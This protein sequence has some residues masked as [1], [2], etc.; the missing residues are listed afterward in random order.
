MVAQGTFGELVDGGVDFVNLMSADEEE[1]PSR[2]SS[3]V[4]EPSEIVV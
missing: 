4:E 2:K 1:T 3:S